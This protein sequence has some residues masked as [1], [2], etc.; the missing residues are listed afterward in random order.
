MDYSS[1]NDKELF[2]LCQNDG[3]AVG[4]IVSRY[5]KTVLALAGK[6]KTGA[7]YEDLVSDGMDALL[8]CV[9]GYDINLGEFSAYVSVSISNRMKNTVKRSRRRASEISDRSEETL[10]TIPD[11]TP[12]P[13]EQFFEREEVKTVLEILN[14]ELTE[15]ERKCIQAAAMGLSYKETAQKL[16]VGE[17]TVDNALS[18]AR[19]KLR[20][21]Y[22][23]K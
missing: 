14:S 1:M 2:R 13:E 5:T 17:K 9:K 18:R 4:E 8:D 16:G 12:T 20:R 22:N 7:D 21:F 23:E 3:A 19:T 15:L 11:P 6:F 10:R